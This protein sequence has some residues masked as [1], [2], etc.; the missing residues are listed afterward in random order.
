MPSGFALGD[1]KPGERMP[2]HL[3]TL[4]PPNGASSGS[5]QPGQVFRHPGYNAPD[6]NA[7]PGPGPRSTSNP[8]R[9]GMM[10]QMGPP[11][12]ANPGNASYRP[13]LAPGGGPYPVIRPMNQGY[14]AAGALNGGYMPQPRS[15]TAPLQARAPGPQRYELHDRVS[16]HSARSSASENSRYGGRPDGSPP[17]PF[18]GDSRSTSIRTPPPAEDPRFSGRSDTS[19]G[20]RGSAQGGRSDS[21]SSSSVGANGIGVSANGSSGGRNPLAE[22]MESEKLFVERLGLIVRV[23]VSGLHL[24]SMRA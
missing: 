23:S 12:H 1:I 11:F 24:P 10:G 17:L 20:A 4:R 19:A 5:V 15:V 16:T 6:H 21:V 9:P 2:M 7:S 8:I 22:L 14:P 13:T 18:P 3:A